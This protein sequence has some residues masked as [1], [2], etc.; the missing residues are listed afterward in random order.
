MEGKKKSVEISVRVHSSSPSSGH[1][2]GCSPLPGVSCDEGSSLEPA[3]SASGLSS[4]CKRPGGGA[5]GSGQPDLS[6][7]DV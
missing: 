5:G 6:V 1:L 2:G 3:E 7:S 4:T